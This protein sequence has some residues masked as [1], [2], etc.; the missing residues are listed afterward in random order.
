MILKVFPTSAVPFIEKVATPLLLMGPGLGSPP[1]RVIVPVVA[2]SMAASCAA[3][4]VLEMVT[5][6]FP[7]PVINFN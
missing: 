3:V 1:L 5:S 4:G 7:F 2:S 6:S